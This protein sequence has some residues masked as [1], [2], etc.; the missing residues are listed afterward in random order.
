MKLEKADVRLNQ[1]FSD[2]TAAITAAGTLLQEQGYVTEEY[3]PKMIERDRMTST[4]IGNLVAIP[5]GTED[6]KTAILKSGIV[7]IQAPEGVSFDGNEV[8]LIIGIAGVENEHLALL[9]EIA[10]VCS[11][12]ENV[13]KLISAQ[14]EAEIIDFF[15]GG[16]AV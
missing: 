6:S 14:N 12:M 11:E 7:I 15:K 8:K 4:F 10:M 1:H 13:E 16:I 5:H 2:K 3:I 9:S